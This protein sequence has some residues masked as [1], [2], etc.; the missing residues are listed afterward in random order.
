MAARLP[1]SDGDMGAGTPPIA[2]IRSRTAWVPRILLI[3]RFSRLTTSA[4]VPAGA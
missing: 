1:K 3:S 4:G 2:E